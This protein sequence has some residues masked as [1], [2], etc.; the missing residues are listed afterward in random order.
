MNL[1]LQV[2]ISSDESRLAY[3]RY[4]TSK[5]SNLFEELVIKDTGIGV[6]I[7][8]L[9]STDTIDRKSVV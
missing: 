8:S 3:V 1:Q 4:S 9:S 2:S 6:G 5:S 7:K